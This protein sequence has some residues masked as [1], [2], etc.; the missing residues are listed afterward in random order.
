LFVVVAPPP[1]ARDWFL[2]FA[3]NRPA[4]NEILPR[5]EFAS[6]GANAEPTQH[7]QAF[8]YQVVQ[9]QATMLSFIDVFWILAIL[10]AAMVRLLDAQAARE[11]RAGGPLSRCAR[12]ELLA[13]DDEA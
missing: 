9:R 7:A 3:P 12:S 10:F 8:L 1:A 5:H 4:G 11:R 6:A 2:A 13:V